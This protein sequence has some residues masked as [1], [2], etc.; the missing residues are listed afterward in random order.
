MALKR[1]Q[2]YAQII[3]GERRCPIAPP[4]SMR[5]GLKFVAQKGDLLQVSYF[6]SGTNWVQYIVQLILSGGEPT[7]NYEEFLRR[8]TIVEYHPHIEEHKTDAPLRT[9]RTHLPL[10]L[11]KLNPEAKYIYVAR[12]PWDVC[13]SLYHFVTSLSCYRFQDGTFDD[14]LEA[15]LTEYLHCGCYFEHL[16]AGYSIKDEP[17]VLFLTYE[18]LHRDIQEVVLRVASFIGEPYLKALME[19]GAEGHKLLDVIIKN[20]SVESMRKAMVFNF[21]GHSL[22]EVDKHFKNLDIT[23][24]SDFEGDNK[25]YNFVRNGKMGVWKQHFSPEQLRRMEAAIRAKT[26]GSSV[27]DL[28]SDIRAEALRMSR[29]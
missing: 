9:L 25:S 19:N 12:N 3:D 2:P 16:V 27:M 10:T 24:T 18:E 6:R 21:S 26:T 29:A 28:W 17:N 5:K 4:E 23:T 15:F 13:V 14:L 8:A 20:S 22:P 7:N 11:E 1:L